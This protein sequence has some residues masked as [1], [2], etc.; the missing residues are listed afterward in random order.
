MKNKRNKFLSGI[1]LPAALALLTFSCQ[2]P[3]LQTRVE[4][5]SDAGQAGE[6]FVYVL[7]RTSVRVS[8]QITRTIEKKGPF[9]DYRE[10][11]L[12]IDEGVAADLVSWSISDIRIGTHA[13]VDP[14]EYYVVQSTGDLHSGYLK[15]SRA[16][17]VLTAEQDLADELGTTQPVV[18]TPA[19]PVFYQDMSVSPPNEVTTEWSYKIQ[20]TDSGFVRV[21]YSFEKVNW[22]SEEE[23]ASEAAEL[24]QKIRKRRLRLVTGQ[25]DFYPEGTALETALAEMKRL[26][27]NYLALFLGKTYT[28][29]F[30]VDYDVVPTMTSIQ[31]ATI[32]CRF[33][34]EHGLVDQADR[35]GVPVALDIRP[36]SLTP[37]L[38]QFS[39][40]H[41][42]PEE[43]SAGAFLV[44]R[45][46]DIATI[47][48][49]TGKEVLA[50]RR[51]LVYQLG[52]KVS[53]PAAVV[54]QGK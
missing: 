47:R 48:V 8:L 14:D 53:L 21:P 33:S 20:E 44:Y 15:L 11:Y 39:P 24:I 17:L 12:G 31:T 5:A 43:E 13:E 42:L 46:P 3:M 1:L 36:E 4:K 16:G 23:K 2:A 41:T 6:G 10:K 54:G 30:V 34:E 25:K 32:L 29:Q 9:Y 22:K 38:K 28:E 40:E 45:V 50:A 19:E 26:E 52:K 18:R 37:P 27:E 49:T 7:P 35:T 51:A